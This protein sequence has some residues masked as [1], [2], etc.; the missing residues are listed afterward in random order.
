MMP[1][2][3]AERPTNAALVLSMV[4]AA[5]G[6]CETFRIAPRTVALK[7]VFRTISFLTQA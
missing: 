6:Q 2:L 4:Y 1:D 7:P 3:G 5:R